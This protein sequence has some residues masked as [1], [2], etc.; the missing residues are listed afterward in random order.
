M[1]PVKPIPP[2]HHTLT[3][4]LTVKG[5]AQA[6]EFYKKALG[7]V[8]QGR[9]LGP[10]DLIMHASIKIGDSIIF[11][12]DEMPGMNKSPQTLGGTPCS[13]TIYTEDS[14]ALFDRAVKAGGKVNMPMADQFW[15]D[16]W[17]AF[18]DPFGHSW[19]VATHKEDVPREEMIERGKAAFAQMGVKP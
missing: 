14:D 6:I 8:E 12:A 5:C 2:E 4:G 16:R 19:S 7:A 17:G 3:P 11:L 10:G 1:S 15:G 9:F 13:I 18:T